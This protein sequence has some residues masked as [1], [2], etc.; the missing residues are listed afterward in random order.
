MCTIL[1]ENIFSGVLNWQL[2]Y[3]LLR[4]IILLLKG[5]L[6]YLSNSNWSLFEFAHSKWKRQAHSL[7]ILGEEVS[8]DAFT[9]NFWTVEPSTLASTK[10]YICILLCTFC[11]GGDNRCAVPYSK[12]L[13]GDIPCPSPRIIARCF[14]PYFPQKNKENRLLDWGKR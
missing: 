9:W 13:K 14:Y 4:F 5:I 10:K 1:F 8:S 2:W 12:R 3:V 6:C 7:T 11:G